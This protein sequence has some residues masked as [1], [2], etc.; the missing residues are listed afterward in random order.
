[1]AS[2]LGLIGGGNMGGA[3]V[4][5]GIEA[6]VFAAREVIVADVD[7]ARL[8][9][10]KSLG[11]ETS[12]DARMAANAMQVVLAVKPQVFGQVA[13][14]IAP[15]AQPKVVISIMAGLRSQAI[16]TALGE[17]ARIVRVMPNTPCQI[18][19]GMSAI[20][21]GDG[22]NPGDEELTLSIF[23]A[24]GRTVMV[25]ESLMYAVTAVSGSGPA[26]VFLLAEAMEQAAVRLGIDQATANLLVKQTVMG[27]GK[28]LA[29][30]EQGAAALR[31]AVTSP[32]GTT[33][34]ALD[35]FEKRQFID[36]VIEALTAARDRG[37]ELD[38]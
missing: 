16:R 38:R 32:G 27:A 35:V 14:A 19:T 12:L 36:A 13:E 11:C 22:A 24:L 28:L 20:A 21:L 7:V 6:G 25:D 18:G 10:F 15:L 29:E 37:H 26:Y 1:M 31:K 5:G 17:A 2:R 33:A 8:D 9:D 4:R 30:S 23:G 3:I 34:A